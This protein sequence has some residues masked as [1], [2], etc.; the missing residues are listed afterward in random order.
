MEDGTSDLPY[1]VCHDDTKGRFLVATRDI[2]PFE[3]VLRDETELVV[4]ARPDA[5]D[6][7]CA[8]LAQGP[9]EKFRC[10]C[11]LTLCSEDCPQR[12]AHPA[13]ECR[14]LSNLK[15][16]AAGKAAKFLLPLRVLRAAENAPA[17]W[18]H[19]RY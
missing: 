11:G 1:R 12:H 6:A 15:P 7:C 4:P 10:A 3:L 9:Q 8:C 18:G 19:I 14:V 16:L 5:G 2:K 13:E 17:L